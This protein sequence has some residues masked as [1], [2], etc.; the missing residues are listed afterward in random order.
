MTGCSV[1]WPLIGVLRIMFRNIPPSDTAGWIASRLADPSTYIGLLD[2]GRQGNSFIKPFLRKAFEFAPR[3]QWKD[4]KLEECQTNLEPL[5]TLKTGWQEIER[6]FCNLFRFLKQQAILSVNRIRGIE[7]RP[8]WPQIQLK[9]LPR[10][11]PTTI[12]WNQILRH[13][14][15]RHQLHLGNTYKVWL[16]SVGFFL[17]LVGQELLTS[18]SNLD[19]SLFTSKYGHADGF[20]LTKPFLVQSNPIQYVFQ[21]VLPP[22]K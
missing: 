17:D 6:I 5:V 13:L 18:T 3:S 20:M 7:P 16:P 9:C 10:D 11:K 19:Q 22:S 1:P 4:L 12:D 21:K 2:T 8:Q 15:C 14:C